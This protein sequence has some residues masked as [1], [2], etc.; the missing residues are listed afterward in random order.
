[1]FC[2]NC[3]S[4]VSPN[5]KYCSSCGCQLTEEVSP[6]NGD[7]NDSKNAVNKKSS[8]LKKS[9]KIIIASVLAVVLLSGIAAAGIRLGVKMANKSEGNFG[10]ASASDSVDPSK[11]R[12]F[13]SLLEDDNYW[14]PMKVEIIEH[15]SLDISE[16]WY[17]KYAQLSPAPNNCHL[18]TS[19]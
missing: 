17:E 12:T 9:S 2:K 7:S 6:V 15:Y 11:I 14:V 18:P 16:D 4:E 5:E 8:G 19:Y 3:G 13:N 1:M 10:D